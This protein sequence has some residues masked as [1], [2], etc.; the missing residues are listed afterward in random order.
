MVACY[1][2]RALFWIDSIK[3][4]RSSKYNLDKNYIAITFV[5]QANSTNQNI[6]IKEF[7]LSQRHDAT[8]SMI[9]RQQCIKN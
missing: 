9:K 3:I 7:K 6:K 1:N 8:A 5:V 4:A 2:D